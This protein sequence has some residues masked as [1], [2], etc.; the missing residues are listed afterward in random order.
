MF[1]PNSL[2]FW[3]LSFFLLMVHSPELLLCF[4][5][6]LFFLQKILKHYSLRLRVKL[7]SMAFLEQLGDYGLA[8]NVCS[9]KPYGTDICL[10]AFILR[11]SFLLLSC[12]FL[13]FVFFLSIKKN[14]M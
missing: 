4:L 14:E 9:L 6:C 5:G 2:A 8:G 13:C 11:F 12:F 3:V 1:L 10:Y 7:S